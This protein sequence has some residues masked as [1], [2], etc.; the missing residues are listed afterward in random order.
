MYAYKVWPQLSKVSNSPKDMS[1]DNRSLLRNGQIYLGAYQL[2]TRCM[3]DDLKPRLR[4]SV[5]LCLK[6]NQFTYKYKD[7]RTYIRG[8]VDAV[9]SHTE[10]GDVVLRPVFI[11]EILERTFPKRWC[12]DDENGWRDVLSSLIEH[13]P[14]AFEMGLSMEKNK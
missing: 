14:V 12:K 9:V 13:E 10:D 8:L 2:A 7:E 4:D 6:V 5:M 3:L 11:R 1:D